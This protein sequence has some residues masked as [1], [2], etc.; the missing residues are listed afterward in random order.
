MPAC[1]PLRHTFTLISFSLSPRHL[2]MMEEEEMLKKVVPHSV[3]TAL[4]SSVFPVPGGPYRRMPCSQ[5]R[6]ARCF[7][8]GMGNMAIC[9][10]HMESLQPS[11]KLGLP[12]GGWAAWPSTS[13][14]KQLPYPP[15]GEDACEQLRPPGRHDHSLLQEVLSSP[16][17]LHIA[18]LHACRA[19][20]INEVSGGVLP[21]HIN[22][23]ASLSSARG[24]W[25][26]AMRMLPPVAL[27][28]TLQA[29]PDTSEMPQHLLHTSPHQQPA[30][31]FGA[32][33]NK[34]SVNVAGPHGKQPMSHA[35]KPMCLC[36]TSHEAAVQQ[37]C[38]VARVCEEG[39]L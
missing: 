33:V 14:H 30:D 8:Q 6:L 15:W 16:Q 23:I 4:A 27:Q 34:S 9:R 22:S 37:R 20:A 10:L 29:A 36:W 39:R 11:F 2:E 26:A 32:P 28:M 17:P 1:T 35:V 5:G 19:T 3:A 24:T 12:G 18:P 13:R 21:D 38:L 25:A 7:P 31:M